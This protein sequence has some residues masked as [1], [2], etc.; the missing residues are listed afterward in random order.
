VQEGENCA[1]LASF[2]KDDIL[3][4]DDNNPAPIL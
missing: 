1:Y 4:F 2:E 3:N